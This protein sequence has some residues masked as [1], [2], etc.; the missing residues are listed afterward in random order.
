MKKILSSLI[1]I[2]SVLGIFNSA[3]VAYQKL[4]NIIPPCAPGFKCTTVL[5]SNWTNLGPV[6]LSVVGI[7][8][9]STFLIVNLV[10]FSQPSKLTKNLSFIL[11]IIALLFA[12][13]LLVV[14]GIILNAWCV[15]CLLS[16]LACVLLFALSTAN[17]SL[18]KQSEMDSQKKIVK[19]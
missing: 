7:I 5:N 1:V 17:F 3:Y 14:M 13:Y 19:N 6:P 10:N 4:N 15:Y 12:I 18:I 2:V 8:F 11:G 16:A 9:F